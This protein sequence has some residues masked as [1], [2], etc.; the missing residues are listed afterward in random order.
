MTNPQNGG[1]NNTILESHEDKEVP[2]NI[3]TVMIGYTMKIEINLNV[4]S[5]S[6]YK[7]STQQPSGVERGIL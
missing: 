4:T 3:S 1:V 6:L 2:E 7:P 5:T